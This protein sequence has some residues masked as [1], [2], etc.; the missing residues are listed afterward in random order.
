M[1]KKYINLLALSTSATVLLPVISASC[2]K[3]K[4][5]VDELETLLSKVKIDIKDKANIELASVTLKNIENYAILQNNAGIS[6]EYENVSVK[7]NSLVVEFKIVKDGK[8][9]NTRTVTITG[10][11]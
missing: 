11:K 8:Q 1:K 2:T 3:N 10:F 4:P 6:I 7:D 9:S 5:E